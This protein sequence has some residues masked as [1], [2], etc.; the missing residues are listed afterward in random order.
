M[1]KQRSRIADYLVYLVIRFIVCILQALSYQQARRLAAGLAWLA[2][3]L[4]RR[5]RAVALDNLTHAY[6]DQLS[7]AERDRMVRGVYLHFCTLLIELVHLGRRLHPCNWRASLE[8]VG[9]RM[10]V[11]GLLS[12][13]SLLIVTAHFGNWELAGYVLGLLG[14]RTYAIA[15]PIDNPYL[16]TYLRDF[17]QRTGQTVLAKKDDFDQIQA[18]LATGG[19]LA[20][21]GDQDAGQRGEFVP[22]FGRL[23]STHKAIALLALEYGVPTL[24]TGTSKIGEP[25]R[26]QVMAEEL[27]RPEEH[28]DDRDG[29]RVGI[30]RRFTAALERL[31][32]RHPE[33]YF[34]LHR[35]W[36][37]QP[38]VRK[39][40]KVA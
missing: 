33:Q 9:G 15:R 16:D 12:G 30:T 25:M 7:P 10:L 39:G 26:Y 14:F 37:H 38:P 20:T 34:W 1:A 27:I 23:A 17:R 40:K 4:D 28:R 8:L 22:F 3:R 29:G 35:R 31:I 2:Y 32:R 13:K 24:V 11:D 5:H 36:K 6:G 21:L 19:A 18:V